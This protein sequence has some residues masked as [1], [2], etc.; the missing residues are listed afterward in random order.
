MPRLARRFDALDANQDDRV[1]REEI[2][3]AR[4]ARAARRRDNAV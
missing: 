3:A 2:D 1:T 4:K